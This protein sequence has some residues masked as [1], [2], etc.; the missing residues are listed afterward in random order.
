MRRKKKGRLARRP[1]IVFT[2]NGSRKRVLLLLRFLHGETLFEGLVAEDEF[3]LLIAFGLCDFALAVVAAERD[4]H[5]PDGDGCAVFRGL[6][7]DGAFGLR[8]LSGFHELLVR[9]GGK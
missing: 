4:F 9:L 5:F 2:M 3:N 6:A 7:S 8:R 1:A